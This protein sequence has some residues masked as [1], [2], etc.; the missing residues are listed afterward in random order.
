M[1]R[2]LRSFGMFGEGLSINESVVYY[3]GQHLTKN[4][5]SKTKTIRGKSLRFN[6]K[7]RALSFSES[8]PYHLKS[9]VHWKRGIIR[10]PKG[11]SVASHPSRK[12][13][14]D[15]NDKHIHYTLMLSLSSTT[16]DRGPRKAMA[17]PPVA[18]KRDQQ[19]FSALILKKTELKI[20]Q[21][22]T[23]NLLRNSE[24]CFSSGLF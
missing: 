15:I 11:E 8:C 14:N 19:I 12:S 3:L 13:I 24:K 4:N 2:N 20:P 6:Y 1:N 21:S 16:K 10:F 23:R 9:T 22:K 7:Q 18:A 5:S 17:P